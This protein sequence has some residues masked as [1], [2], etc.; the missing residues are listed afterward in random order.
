LD[1]VLCIGN[2]ARIE[3]CPHNGWGTHN[4]DHSE[5]AGVVCLAGKYFVN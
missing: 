3:Y 2:E 5:D 4:C 1:D